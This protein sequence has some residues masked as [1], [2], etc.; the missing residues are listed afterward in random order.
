MAISLSYF[1]KRK[2]KADRTSHKSSKHR[3][4]LAAFKK[5][6]QAKKAKKKEKKK[7]SVSQHTPGKKY[8][9]EA[10]EPRLLLS[11]DL[12]FGESTALDLR[13]ND[14]GNFDLADDV[15]ELVDDNNVVIDSAFRDILDDRIIVSGQC[16]GR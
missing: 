2:N 13:L 4:V 6:Q 15:F 14:Q 12:A 16:G 5:R 9:L 11:A 8:N 10:L 1:G 7:R 3:D